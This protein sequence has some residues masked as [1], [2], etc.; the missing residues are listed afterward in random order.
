MK[1]RCNKCKRQL[2]LKSFTLNSSMAD[3]YAH[4]CKTCS[5]AAFRS[6]RMEHNKKYLEAA[7][8]R[9][10]LI[11]TALRKFMTYIKSNLPCKNC[12]RWYLKECMEFDH[13]ELARHAKN[14]LRG[15]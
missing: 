15:T 3:G 14:G 12:K 4:Y 9:Y 6:Y 7:R 10:K 11:H 2:S 5:R 1:K 13:Y 8:K